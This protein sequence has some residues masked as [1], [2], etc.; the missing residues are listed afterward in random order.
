MKVRYLIAIYKLSPEIRAQFF[1]DSF[2]KLLYNI[3]MIEISVTVPVYNV[4]K[5]L[6]RCLNSIL[7]Q[8]FDLN[9]EVICVDDGSTDSSPVILEAFAQKYPDKVKVIRQENQG[10]SVARNTAMEYVQGKYTMFV[11]SDDF[12]ASNM[13]FKKLYN[14]AQEHSSDVVIFDFLRGTEE[15]KNVSRQHFPNIKNKYGDFTFNAFLAEPFVYRFIP[16]ATWAKFYLTD[17]VKDIKFVPDLNN[18]D[19][20]HWAQVYTKASKINYF[21]EPFYFYTIGREGAITT[22]KG[23]KAFDVFKAFSLEEEVLKKS[24]YF[25]KFKS[26]HY[27]HFCS[28]L[29][30]RLRR[31]EPTIRKDFIEEIKKLNIDLDYNKFMQEDFF[32]FEKN[33]VQVIKSIQENKFKFIKKLLRDR[34]IWKK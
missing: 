29:I 17:L 13:A 31:I 8:S 25:E 34:G 18:Q 11:D 20:V 24:G 23:R 28:N 9:Y 12:L 30:G 26:I 2:Y 22:I 1:F 10:L 27:A 32:P 16:V 6:I 19:V 14:Y 33:D 5:Y 15:L 3:C 7:H 4:E 21:P